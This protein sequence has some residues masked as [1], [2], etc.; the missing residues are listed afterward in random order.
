MRPAAFLA[1]AML[2]LAAV[3]AGGTLPRHTEAEDTATTAIS[4]C[5]QSMGA[6]VQGEHCSQSS[7]D[8]TPGMVI[9]HAVLRGACAG[10]DLHVVRYVPDGNKLTSTLVATYCG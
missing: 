9:S 2:L 7:L 6:A 8:G 3:I 10:A 4:D 1:A 5:A